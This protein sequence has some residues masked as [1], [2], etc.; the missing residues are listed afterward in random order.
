MPDVN[1]KLVRVVVDDEVYKQ[2]KAVGDDATVKAAARH[3]LVAAHP[4]HELRKLLGE[5]HVE[6]FDDRASVGSFHAANFT[7]SVKETK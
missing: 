1:V 6:A 3:I 4:Q 2:D 5:E 7:L